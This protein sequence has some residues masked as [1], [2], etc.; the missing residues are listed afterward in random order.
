MRYLENGELEF[1]GR[2]DHQVKIRGFR[3][4]L[5]EIES[6]LEENPAV[7]DV[8][9]IVRETETIGKQIVAYIVLRQGTDLN[10]SELQRLLREKLPEHMIPSAFV[11]LDKLPLTPSGKVDR[12]AL[13][14]PDL[15]TQQAVYIAP[16][17]SIE[18]AL[19][20]IWQALLGVERVGITDNFFQLGGHSLLATRLASRIHQQYNVSLPLKTVFAEQTLE[21]LAQAIKRLD[22]GLDHPPL[23]RIPREGHLLPSYAQQRLWLLDQIDGGSAHY[24]ISGGLRL[25]GNLDLEALNQAFTTILNRHESLRTCFA[26]GE[27]GQPY[28]VIQSVDQFGVAIQDL[29]QLAGAVQQQTVDE[30]LD[31][32]SHRLF[33]LRTDLMLHAQLIKVSATEHILL[34]TMHHIASDGWSIT[35]L[36]N[37]LNALY[38]AYSQGR[39]NPLPPLEIQYVDYAHWQRNWLQGDVLE[40]QLQYWEGQLAGLPLVH[41]LPLDHPRPKVQ[42]FA[43]RLHRS[44][45]DA[46]TRTALHAVCQSRG[47]TLFMGLHAA[48]STLLARYS[49]ELDIVLGSPIANREQAEIAGLIGF[50]VNTLVLRSDLSDNPSFTDLLD[51]SKRTLLDAYAHQQVPFEQLVERLQPERSLS[52]SP[53]FQVMLVLQNN[54]Q[55]TLSLPGLTLSPMEQTSVRLAKFDLT[56]YVSE[57]MDGLELDWEYNSD[58][59]ESTTIQ[60]MAEHF[61]ILLSSLVQAPKNSVFEA[62]M[63]S[64]AERHRLLVAWNDTTLEYP[65][66]KCIHELFEEQA[67]LIP[68]ATAVTFKELHLTYGELNKKANQLAH[69]LITEKRVTPDTPVGIC[70]ERSIDMIVAILGILKAGGAYVP[71]DPDYPPAR[72]AYMLADAN[73]TIV[74]THTHL[75]NRL[76]SFSNQAVCLDALDIHQ[77]L[78]SQPSSNPS[79]HQLGLTPRH[80]AYIIYTSGSTG[81]PKGVKA[82]HTSILN[83]INWLERNFPVRSDDVFCQKTAAGFV[84]HVAEIFQALAYGKPLIV[85]STHDILNPD[86]FSRIV[87]QHRI[88]RITL[89]PSL[90]KQLIEQGALG[91]MTSLRLV[92]SS[93]EA[94]QVDD[95]QNFN[96]ALPTATLLN[97]YGSSEVGADV[98]AYWVKQGDGA[99]NIPIGRPIDNIQV[100]ILN[101]Q[102]QLVPQGMTGELHIGGV[103]LARGYLNRPELTAEKFIP[104]PFFDSND[105]ASSPRLFKTGDLVRWL[106]EGNIEFLGRIDHQVKI[107]GFRIELGEI[108]NTLTSHDLVKDAVVLVKGSVSVNKYLVAYVV[109]ESLE[110]NSGTTIDQLRSHLSQ[111]LPEYMI[112]S[113]FVILDKMPL[114]PSGK[115][116]R[117]ALPEPDPSIQQTTYMAPHTQTEKA[118]CEIWQEILGVERVGLHR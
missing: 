79:P 53:L 5:G 45:I 61:H 68:N 93:G 10:R 100:Y 71:L 11:I 115:V 4:E 52:H 57:G 41:S 1:L 28:Q 110:Y 48:F 78:A 73:L 34:V 65:K 85:I 83:R 90:L 94:L 35:I 109:T 98:T 67:V 25:S 101:S 114:T 117:R 95:A 40:Q 116:D 55:G 2:I 87:A 69:Y 89:V 18:K 46:N 12:K 8:E 76:P 54:E 72:L 51:Q 91:K 22:S 15:S 80:L 105:P 84:D 30:L 27:D 63:L 60:R 97:L 37:E 16:R 43:G 75:L 3:V 36:I 70:I 62:N 47:A 44:Q 74:I 103:G 39:E 21:H 118:L 86:T 82:P 102:L 19:C 104:N 88:T 64:D 108:E 111:S 59:F 26:I 42:S 106:P 112:P 113:A 31:T 6:V 9:V 81:N 29:S 77:Q 56:L 7:I 49:N 96:R 13:P 38:S 24:N 33:D 92:I 17:T 14:E 66:E 58:L 23:V 99:N 107:R 32:E 50:F 20:E